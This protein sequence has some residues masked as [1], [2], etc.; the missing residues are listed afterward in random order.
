[1]ISRPVRSHPPSTPIRIRCV[2]Y[3]PIMWTSLWWTRAGPHHQ[4]SPRAFPVASG[5]TLFRGFGRCF[6]PSDGFWSSS[7]L[8]PSPLRGQRLLLPRPRRGAAAAEVGTAACVREASEPAWRLLVAALTQSGGVEA[9]TGVSL[10]QQSCLHC[11]PPSSV[12]RSPS[13]TSPYTPLTFP[14]RC[15]RA[16]RSRTSLVTTPRTWMPILQRRTPTPRTL[17]RSTPP[18]PNRLPRHH[19]SH[20]PRFASPT[21]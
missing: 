17:F 14:T 18:W 8:G 11:E 9:S 4:K 7:H 5:Y 16:I 13:S 3:T 19:N 15:I 1:M 2:D 12:A 21:R 6:T 10:G 20:G